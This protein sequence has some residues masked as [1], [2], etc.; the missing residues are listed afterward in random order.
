VKSLTQKSL[1]QK[2][3][4][5]ILVFASALALVLLASLASSRAYAFSFSSYYPGESCVNRSPGVTPYY[6]SGAI[7]NPSTTDWLYL[8]C[9]MD[10]ATTYDTGTVDVIDQNGYT[11]YDV[12]CAQVGVHW[13]YNTAT[14]YTGGT[15]N[16]SGVG[17]QKQTLSFGVA[18]GAFPTVYYYS[19]VI[20]PA[21]GG[22]KN[23]SYI[24]TYSVSEPG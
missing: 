21:Y 8:D 3:L 2:S 12:S 13:N 20:P 22:T 16:S 17:T 19:C 15:K 10:R 18:Q 23:K 1:T 14:Y 4:T 9:P 5:Q 11:G 6:F 7:G 24:E